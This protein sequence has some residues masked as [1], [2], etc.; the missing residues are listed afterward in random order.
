MAQTLLQAKLT[1]PITDCSLGTPW[2]LL[3]QKIP[4][5]PK[6]DYPVRTNT[7]KIVTLY[8]PLVKAAALFSTSCPSVFEYP[9][10]LVLRNKTECILEAFLPDETS[11]VVMASMDNKLRLNIV[12]TDGTRTPVGKFSDMSDSALTMIALT[13]LRFIF[14]YDKEHGNSMIIEAATTLDKGLAPS[15]SFTQAHTHISTISIHNGHHHSPHTTYSYQRPNKKSTISKISPANQISPGTL[16]RRFRTR[17]TAAAA[18]SPLCSRR[19]TGLSYSPRTDI[20]YM[21][22]LFLLLMELLH[23]RSDLNKF[24]YTVLTATGGQHR[25]EQEDNT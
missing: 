24:Q 10:R 18:R 8:A 1:K 2:D 22:H 15:E 9:F 19:T 6:Y 23:R 3:A 14:E 11:F 12:E 4:G 16:V 20:V 7:I 21:M 5:D 17:Q 25:H 13:L